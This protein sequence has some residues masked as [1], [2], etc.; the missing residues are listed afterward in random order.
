M[1]SVYLAQIN[2]YTWLINKNLHNYILEEITNNEKI[3]YITKNQKK[4]C[5][6]LIPITK[7]KIDHD[8]I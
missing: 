2:F 8:S 6:A 3:T 1:Y 7:I 5:E 4:K